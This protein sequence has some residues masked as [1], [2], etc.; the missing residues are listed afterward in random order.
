MRFGRIL[1]VLLGVGLAGLAPISTAEAAIQA[2]YE[3]RVVLQPQARGV[4][5]H[6]QPITIRGR[7]EVRAPGACGGGGEWCLAPDTK[8]GVVTI[9]RVRAGMT[10]ETTVATRSDES[11]FR[12]T[13]RSVGN[14]TYYV[15][16]SGGHYDGGAAYFTPVTLGRYIKGSRNPHGEAVARDRALWFV[17]DVDPGWARQAVTIQKK[18]CRS[19]AWRTYRELRTDRTGHYATKI[20]APR[21]GK[22]Y[23]RSTLAGTRPRFVRAYSAIWWTAR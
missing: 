23:W 6:R 18:N 13:T 16:Y 8:D 1:I 21:R 12:A 22:W 7:V 11:S 10:N 19:C 14:A 20:A 9:T 15:K 17:G 5:W 4:Y 3:T 2:S